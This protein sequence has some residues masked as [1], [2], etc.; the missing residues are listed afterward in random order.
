MNNH[1]NNCLFIPVPIYSF[2]LLRDRRFAFSQSTECSI[3]YVQW[4]WQHFGYYFMQLNSLICQ[5]WH[6]FSLKWLVYKFSSF[7]FS[8]SQLVSCKVL[9]SQ[10]MTALRQT[11]RLVCL[12]CSLEAVDWVRQHWNMLTKDRQQTKYYET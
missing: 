1:H 8:L 5:R 6:M 4:V 9:L 11:T 2:T 10:V 3:V 7:H 12:G